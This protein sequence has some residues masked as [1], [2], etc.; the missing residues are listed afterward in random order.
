MYKKYSEEVITALQMIDTDSA[1][2]AINTVRHA[3]IAGKCVFLLGNGGSAATASHMTV[4]WQKGVANAI[5]N[6]IHVDCLTDNIPLLTAYSNDESY[7]TALGSI[8]RGKASRDDLVIFIS[9]SGESKN[10]LH[11]AKI[12]QEI[13]CDTL[14]LTG[15][16]GGELCKMTRIN[17]NV[18]SNSM[19]VIEDI[20]AM[21]GHMVLKSFA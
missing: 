13:G 6:N 3:L 10:I 16:A 8:L 17:L 19:Q 2:L 15:F 9:G 11:A 18:P 7:E 14:S 20:H 12:A 21:F 5:K 4:D 1:D